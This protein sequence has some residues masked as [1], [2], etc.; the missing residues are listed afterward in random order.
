MGHASLHLL[1]S[2][3]PLFLFI[4]K[5]CSREFVPSLN[6]C[7]VPLEASFTTWPLPNSTTCLPWEPL[8]DKVRDNVSGLELENRSAYKALPTTAT[9]VFHAWFVP[10][11]GKV[12]S[13]SHNLYF[14]VLQWGCVF[15]G[16]FSSSHTLRIQFFTC[17]RICSGLLLL[18]KDLRFLSVFWY[19]PA[20]VP[21][22]KVY[23]VS[24]HISFCSF[25]WELYISPVFYPPISLHFVFRCHIYIFLYCVSLTNY[26]SYY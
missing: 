20:V 25:K 9:F 22:A 2:F 18:S 15:R 6:Y 14:Q 11:L 7:K 16:K 5:L 23:C 3:L 13:V 8:W 12:K 4:P 17:L 10:T 26:C 24:L 1:L 19:A 21:G